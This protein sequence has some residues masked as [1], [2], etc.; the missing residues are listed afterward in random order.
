MSAFQHPVLVGREASQ[1]I[2]RWTVRTGEELGLFDRTAIGFKALLSG[3]RLAEDV[4]P[5]PGDPQPT[6]GAAKVPEIVAGALLD[7][8]A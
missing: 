1:A 7:S 2:M 5:R 3:R 4:L 6:P 8:R